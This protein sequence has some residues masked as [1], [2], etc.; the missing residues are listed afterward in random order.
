MS[1]APVV[2]DYCLQHQVV[3]KGGFLWPCPL[4]SQNHP[5]GS[6]Y[7]INN[8]VLSTTYG[9]KIMDALLQEES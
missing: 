3:S 5:S 2:L 4:N 7:G 1:I 9:C 6:Q 8:N